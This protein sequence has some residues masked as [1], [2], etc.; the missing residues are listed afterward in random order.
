MVIFYL[1]YAFN[2]LVPNYRYQP[3]HV[4]VVQITNHYNTKYRILFIKNKI[5]NST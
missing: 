5:V 2:K 1:M 4:I 3:T